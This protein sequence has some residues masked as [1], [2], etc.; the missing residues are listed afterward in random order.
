MPKK[1]KHLPLW[2]LCVVLIAIL[3]LTLLNPACRYLYTKNFVKSSD[4]QMA[5][6]FT[7][8]LETQGLM[9]SDKPIFFFGS[10]GTRTNASCLDLSTGNYNIYSVFDAADA[11]GMN[12]LEAS[13]HILAYLNDL[14]YAYTVPT[15]ADWS[16]YENEM[17]EYLPL[18]NCFPWYNSILETEHCIIVQLS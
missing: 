4:L 15:A 9:N 2:P 13:Q 18:E 8:D 5:E 3:I 1:K 7:S 10:A 17:K 11:L 12:T 14:G 16:K 6:F